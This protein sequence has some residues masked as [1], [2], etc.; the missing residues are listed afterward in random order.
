M[1]KLSKI[2][3]R[4]FQKSQNLAKISKFH[5]NFIKF[6]ISE[7]IIS[8]L[9][10]TNLFFRFRKVKKHEKSRIFEKIDKNHDFSTI[11]RNY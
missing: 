8:A 5:E 2:Q 4:D 10:L 9:N 6:L 11:F 1:Q 3:T 7:K